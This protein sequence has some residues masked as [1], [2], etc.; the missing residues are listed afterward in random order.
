MTQCFCE[1][2]VKSYIMS[3]EDEQKRTA[4]LGQE[5]GRDEARAVLEATEF[6][7]LSLAKGGEAYSIPVSFGFDAE[8]ETIYFMLAFDAGSKKR[9]FLDAT[10]RATLTVTLTDLPDEWRSVVASGRLAAVSGDEESNAYTALAATASFPA[11]YT[12]ED[13]FDLQTTE[14]SLY[15]MTV[16]SLGARGAQHGDRT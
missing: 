15:S 7:V 3:T 4:L 16:D 11:M 2:L 10:T 8:L 12:F 1:H 5:A 14:Q 9:E 13:Y 6:G